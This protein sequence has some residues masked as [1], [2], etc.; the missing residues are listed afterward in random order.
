VRHLIACMKEL[1]PKI[2]RFRKEGLKE[3]PTR[4]LFIDLLLKS[5]GWDVCDPDEV[6]L[7]Y[8]TIDGK[9]VDYALK[10][11]GKPILLVKAKGLN[12]SLGDVKDITQTTGYAA[13]DGIVWCILTNGVHW[14]V[15]HS[16]EQCPAPEKGM[17]KPYQVRQFLE[18]VEAH[19]LE[20][21]G[22]V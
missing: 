13:N 6:Q 5:L 3:T 10:I 21:G 14:R 16:I 2:E 18:L 22:G 20:L 12:D 11:N 15:Y 19:N 4:T 7:E 8:P 9:S 1:Q 17:V